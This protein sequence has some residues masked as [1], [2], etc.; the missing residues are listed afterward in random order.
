MRLNH[1]PDLFLRCCALEIK[2]YDT[3]L[4][5]ATNNKAIFEIGVI[6]RLYFSYTKL[7]THES[8]GELFD[9]DIKVMPLMSAVC[10]TKVIGIHTT[11]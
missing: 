2:K 8:E 11:I 6:F 3:K 1:L 9:I 7:V 4:M 5:M 10:C